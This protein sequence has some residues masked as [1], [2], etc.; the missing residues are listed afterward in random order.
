M[1]ARLTLRYLLLFTVVLVALSAG[2]YE[3]LAR[4]YSALLGPALATPE[5]GAA[6]AAALRRVGLTIG[7]FDLPL[8]ALFGAVS[9]MLARSSLEP[10]LQ[11]QERERA[12][13]ADAAHALRSPLATI[14]TLAQAESA[15]A[16][17]RTARQ[18][19]IITRAAL[20]ASAVVGDLLTLARSARDGALDREPVDVA[21]LLADVAREYAV[22]AQERGIAIAV[23]SSSAIVEADERRLRELARNLLEN[24]LR[25]AASSVRAEVRVTDGEAWVLVSNDGERVADR[26][27]SKI[28]ERFYRSDAQSGGSGL[29]LAI[30]AWV[31]R[32]HGGSVSVRDAQPG[33]AEFVVRLPL[34]ASPS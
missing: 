22:Q 8:L 3:F 25:H 33:G 11:A 15:Q 12:F 13:A 10:L 27:K 9:W 6:Y 31:A 21:A 4:E 17:P 18:F 1:I 23:I 30:V 19:A 34:M 32:A 24:A 29:G 20:D 16:D 26:E 14:A 5:G 7:A 2:G 28:F